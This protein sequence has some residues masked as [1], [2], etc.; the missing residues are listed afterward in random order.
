M[1]RRTSLRAR[2]QAML[3]PPSIRPDPYRPPTRE[4]IERARAM[5]GEGFTVSRILA[6]CDMSFGTLDHWLD[7]GPQA[8]PPSSSSAISG[9]P[10]VAGGPQ[11]GPATDQSAVGCAHTTLYPPLPRR[12]RVLGKRRKPLSGDRVSLAARLWRT[13]ELQARDLEERL[14]RPS[15]SSPERERNLRMFGAVVRALRDLSAFDPARGEAAA[16]P[17][18]APQDIDAFRHELARRI[19]ALVDAADARKAEAE[20]VTAAL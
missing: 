12:R 1:T 7:G 16:E 15:G 3:H 19:H 14:A 9:R 6:A 10:D 2:K 11:V 13:A 8:G 4:Q 20:S 18:T 17:D 5:Y